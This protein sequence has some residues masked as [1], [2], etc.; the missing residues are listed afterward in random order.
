MF[1]QDFKNIS[2]HIMQERFKIRGSNQ[3]LFVEM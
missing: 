2:D 3:I 1:I